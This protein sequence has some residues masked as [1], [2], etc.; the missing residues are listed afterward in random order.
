VLETDDEELD[1]I[2]DV[3]LRGVWNC[4]NVFRRATPIGSQFCPPIASYF[5]LRAR[6]RRRV[7]GFGAA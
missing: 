4:M 6:P 2:I 1:T 7:I 3:N 5:T